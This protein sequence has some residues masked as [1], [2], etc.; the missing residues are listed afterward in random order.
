VKLEMRKLGRTKLQVSAIGI[1]S[2]GFT[3]AGRNVQEVQ[4]I[5]NRALDLGVNIIDTASGYKAG[6]IEEMIGP[7]VAKRRDECIVLSRSE[8]RRAREFSQALEGS[9]KRLKVD[10]IDIYQLHDVTR[11]G[12][13]EEVMN[14]G[15]ALD[16]LKKARDLGKVKFLGVSTHA[17]TEEVKA[18]LSSDEFDVI[19]IAYN[20]AYQKRVF[21]D[22]EDMRQ[23]AEELFP[24][25]EAYDVGLTIMKPF[26]GGVLLELPPDENGRKISPVQLL[27]FCLVDPRVHTVTPGIGTLEELEEDIQ[28]GLAGPR[29][30]PEEVDELKSSVQ[31]LGSGFCRQCGYCLPC[32][33][34]IEIPKVM[35]ILR[36]F[37]RKHREQRKQAGEE[38]MKLEVKPD[39][40]SGCG[41]CEERCPYNIPIQDK[42]KEAARIG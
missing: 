35:R 18:M 32:T 1:G 37:K 14:P 3:R 27:K 30:S 10:C 6:E 38:L 15:G 25:A 13:Y 22:G 16:A 34:K 4:A 17:K 29:L 40:C 19:T 36:L 5:L 39:A 2:L 20:V 11:P 9:L 7:V 41:K 42:M 26:G 21:E 8:K 12:E 24:L 31:R 28:A 33:E 23:T